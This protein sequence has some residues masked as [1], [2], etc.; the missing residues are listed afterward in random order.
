MKFKICQKL[1]HSFIIGIGI[2]ITVPV[3]TLQLS[4][5]ALI[6]MRG[7]LSM[8]NY[9]VMNVANALSL[10]IAANMSLKTTIALAIVPSVLFL[11]GILTIILCIIYQIF[12]PLK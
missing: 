5:I 11:T 1:D 4:E 7:C 6:N 2:G 3:Q 8:M 9:L 10:L 12:I